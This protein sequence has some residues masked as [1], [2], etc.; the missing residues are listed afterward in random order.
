MNEINLSNI[1]SKIYVIRG[2]KIMLD[3]DLA[4]LYGVETKALKQAVKRNIKRFPDDFMFSPTINE[5][6]DLR[7]Q[8]VTANAV[9]YWNHVQASP[10]LF[11]ESGVAMLS[12]I[13]N[14]D[15]AIEINISIMRIFRKLRSYMVLDKNNDVDELKRNTNKMFQTVFERLDSIEETIQPRLNPKRKK[16]GLKD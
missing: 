2:Q 8:F 7:S 4:E 12:S 3:N 13:L 10:Y 11:T 16:I 9:S 5:L 6:A 14:S 15:R 1:E